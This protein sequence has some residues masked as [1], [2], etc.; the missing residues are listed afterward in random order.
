MEYENEHLYYGKRGMKI[1]RFNSLN[2]TFLKTCM[3]CSNEYMGTRTQRYCGDTC[4]PYIYIKK[5]NQ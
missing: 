4:R 3:T 1:T 2:R 5:E